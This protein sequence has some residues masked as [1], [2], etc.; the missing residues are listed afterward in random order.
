VSKLYENY[1][2]SDVISTRNQKPRNI[3]KTAS[4][5]IIIEM[6]KTSDRGKI[7]E[8]TRELRYITKEKA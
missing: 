1:K 2:A 6:F 3:N 7:L 8:T 4:R 5:H